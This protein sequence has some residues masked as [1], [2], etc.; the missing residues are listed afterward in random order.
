MYEFDH[1]QVQRRT[2][3]L[4]WALFLSRAPSGTA[5]V[6]YCCLHTKNSGLQSIAVITGWWLQDDPAPPG[7]TKVVC[8]NKAERFQVSIDRSNRYVVVEKASVDSDW[9]RISQR[10]LPSLLRLLPSARFEPFPILCV[11]PPTAS[12]HSMDHTLWSFLLAL[13]NFKRSKLAFN[14]WNSMEIN[15]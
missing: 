14:E 12:T 1:G 3:R 8:S 5:T 9:L 2:F 11:G 7:R 6:Q 4:L 13:I 15:L 10:R